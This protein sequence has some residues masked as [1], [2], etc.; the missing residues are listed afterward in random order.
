MTHMDQQNLDIEPFDREY[1]MED[2]LPQ[3]LLNRI[4]NGC[5]AMLPEQ[6]ALFTDN[7]K[8]HYQI[9]PWR[10]DHINQLTAF[11]TERQPDKE[12]SID[13]SHDGRPMLFPIEYE[14]EIIGYISIHAQ[15][16]NETSVPDAGRNV[17]HLLEQFMRLNHQTMLTSGLHGVVVEES[18]EQLQ[19]KANQL[20]Q[21]EEKYRHLAEN[22][23]IEVQKKNRRY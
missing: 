3:D 4:G 2:L 23:E 6:W 9:G 10:P 1:Q 17:V 11:I 5:A 16:K 15:G 7:G 22:L 13:L 19:Q 18:Y 21:S 12:G 20:A 8:L 14:L